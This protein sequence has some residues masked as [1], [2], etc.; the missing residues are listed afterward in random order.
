M[1]KAVAGILLLCVCILFLGTAHAQEHAAFSIVRQHLLEHVADASALSRAEIGGI[2]GDLARSGYAVPEEAC[3]EKANAYDVAMDILQAVLGSYYDWTIEERHGFDR[4]M[5]DCGELD[6][7][8]NLLPGDGEIAKEDAQR[9]AL[10]EIASRYALD[11]SQLDRVSSLSVSYVRAEGSASGGKWRFGVALQDQMSFGVE[12]TDG[13]VTRCEKY[14]AVDDLE[15]AYRL[16][17]EQRGAFFKWSLEDKMAFA[18]SLP[19]KLASAKERDTLLSSSVELEAIA[20]YGF[21]LPVAGALSQDEACAV[22]SDAMAEAFGIAREEC[23]GVYYSFFRQEE[24]AY[25]WRVIFWDTGDAEHMIVVVDLRAL[26]G[27]IL[28]VRASGGTAG[29]AI[30]YIERL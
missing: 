24:E 9:I 8:Y 2:I 26:T 25:V 17:C 1:R 14:A 5:V 3:G 22:A 12:V 16:L 11:P 6:R 4:M 21:C 15:E 7:C 27:E 18:D 20:A 30:P 13:V 23:A 19:E 28:T 10:G 29:E